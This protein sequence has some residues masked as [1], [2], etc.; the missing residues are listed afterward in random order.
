MKL[1]AVSIQYAIKISRTTGYQFKEIFKPGNKRVEAAIASYAP[2]LRSE[3][4]LGIL[5]Y[6]LME[7]GKKGFLVTETHIY[8]Y[9]FSKEPIDFTQLENV[10][11]FHKTVRLEY[12]DGRRVKLH[13]SPCAEQLG[14]LLSNLVGMQKGLVPNGHIDTLERDYAQMKRRQAEDER[15]RQQAREAWVHDLAKDVEELKR[16]VAFQNADKDL[17]DNMPEDDPLKQQILKRRAEES[18]KS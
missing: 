17:L 10:S 7:N 16:T 6:T 9:E 13:I 5:D 3:D 15:R 11:W 1:D 2:R 12:A 14:K 8:G 4:V 18:E